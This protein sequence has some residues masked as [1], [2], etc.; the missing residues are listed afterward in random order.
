M[1]PSI[2]VHTLWLLFVGLVSGKGARR[3]S[4]FY[5]PEQMYFGCTRKTYDRN[6]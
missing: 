1:I 2:L 6:R 3:Q 5:V 4:G